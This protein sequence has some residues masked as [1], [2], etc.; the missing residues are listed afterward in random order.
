MMVDTQSAGQSHGRLA[1]LMERLWEANRANVN[2]M[3]SAA[4]ASLIL[5]LAK[6]AV[7]AAIL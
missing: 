7:R 3:A 6:C 2:R 4:H 1:E 5:V